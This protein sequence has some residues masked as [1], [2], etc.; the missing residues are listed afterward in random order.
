MKQHL[1]TIRGRVVR[2]LWAD[3][4]PCDA[5]ALVVVLPGLG[6]THYTRPTAAAVASR[7][8]SCAVLDLPGFGSDRPWPARPDI[9]AIG[10]TAARWVE[11][12]APA[13]PVVVLGHST[14]AQAALT[15]A[16]ALGARRAGV[17]L[18]MAGP[19]FCPPQ[20]R[21]TGLALATTLAYR[22]DRP[23][24]LDPAETWRGRAGILAI[25]G[26]GLRD[27]PDERIAHLKV[28]VTLTSGVDDAYAPFEW[29]DRLAASAVKAPRTRT[30][31]LGGSHNNLFTH[32]EQV[33]D[34]VVLAAQDA[35]TAH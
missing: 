27:A 16:L 29:L 33:A 6:L 15:A 2:S 17:S 1:S 18:V 22:R 21:L 20:R 28:P 4:G 30:A 26:S 7:G 31:R 5:K 23:D 19:T 32:P 34:L 9:N 35:A 3:D 24:E 8:L 14:G 25:L 13:R 10:L 12:H 11:T